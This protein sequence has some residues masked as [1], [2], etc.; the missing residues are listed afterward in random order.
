M[1][2]GQPGITP[3]PSLL[4]TFFGAALAGLVACGIALILAHNA[5]LVNPTSDSLMAAARFGMLATFSTG[6]LGAMHQFT[7]IVA[8]RPLRSVLLARITLVAWLLA[9]WIL[10]LGILTRHDVAVEA[11]VGFAAVTVTLLTFNL[12]TA[13]WIKGKGAPLIGLRCAIAGFI[14]TVYFGVVY[15]AY[16]RG[17]LFNLSGHVVLANATVG[18]FVWLGLTYVSI[19]EKRWPLFFLTDVPAKHQL[20]LVAVL[21]IPLGIVLLSPGLLLEV[22]L[23]AW[24]GGAIITFGLGSHLLSFAAYL[25]HLKRKPDLYLIYLFTAFLWMIA[26][27][28]LA[29][30]AGLLISSDYH[31]GTMLAAASV[32][33]F[34]G[35]ILETTVGYM[36]KVIPFVL[37]SIARGRGI[38]K[39]PSGDELIFGDLYNHWIAGT[40]YGFITIGIG[41]VCVALAISEP[42]YLITGG[43]LFALAGVLLGMNIFAKSIHILRLTVTTT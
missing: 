18:L 24:A 19:A 3:P 12:W 33:A 9:S 30:T 42:T 14:V 8:Q 39:N 4:L 25:H 37:W 29:L 36:H 31:L 7:P 41:S 38:E 34:G 11:G 26:G 5:G 17:N 16:R 35:W 1:L 15:V 23:L 43:S 32:A 10:P 6:T 28:A 20:E 21:A 13:L 2:P 22:P 40:A 27:M